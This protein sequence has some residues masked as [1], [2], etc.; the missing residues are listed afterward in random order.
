MNILSSEKQKEYSS[1]I[2][3]YRSDYETRRKNVAKIEEKYTSQQNMNKLI[4][5][6]GNSLSRSDVKKI[7]RD[8]ILDY[9]KKVDYQGDLINEIGRDLNNAQGNLTGIVKEVK[10]QGET[11]VRIKDNVQEAGTSVKRADKNITIMQRRSFCQKLLLHTLAVALLIAN[12]TIIVYKVS[13]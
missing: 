7:E 4:T 11:I 10:A 3:I 9:D 2:K 8:A 5:N 1:K 13:K 6:T 12:V